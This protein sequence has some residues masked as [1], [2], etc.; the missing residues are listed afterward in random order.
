MVFTEHMWCNSKTTNLHVLSCQDMN[1]RMDLHVVCFF[2]NVD[3]HVGAKYCMSVFTCED[4]CPLAH[5]IGGISV[6]V[7]IGAAISL[8]WLEW[9]RQDCRTSS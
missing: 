9:S 6:D 8:T 2:L 3:Q 7:S 5:K 1:V 4:L